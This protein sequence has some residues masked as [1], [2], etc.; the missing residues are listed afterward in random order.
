MSQEIQSDS[1][2][3]KSTGIR[4][5]FGPRDV[6]AA[7]LLALK[8]AHHPFD[9]ECDCILCF[10]MAGGKILRVVANGVVHYRRGPAPKPLARTLRQPG[11]RSKRG[12][13]VIHKILTAGER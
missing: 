3:V 2:A 1:V 6:T 13:S 12:R 4:V 10:A 8:S 7:E 11:A 5:P 9:R